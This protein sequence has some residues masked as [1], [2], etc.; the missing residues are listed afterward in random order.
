[1]KT[2]HSRTAFM[3]VLAMSLAGGSAAQAEEEKK[4]Q[5][6]GEPSEHVMVTAADLQ[7]ADGPLPSTKLVVLE[8]DPKTPGPFTMRLKLPADYRIPPHWHPAHERVTVI[9]GT[10]NVGRG[11]QF[12]PTKG[13]T[14]PAGSFML[15]PPKTNHFAWVK[16]ET[17]IQINGIGPWALNFVNPADDPRN[18]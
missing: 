9:S 4:M 2:L 5:S 18:K 8:G 16:E 15:M 13:K 1:M 14:M 17:I 7:W 11:D 10:F 12:D 3:I 6:P